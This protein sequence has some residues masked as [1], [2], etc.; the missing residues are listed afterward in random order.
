M[1]R[2]TDKLKLILMIIEVM[3]DKQKEEFT[4]RQNPGIIAQ[5]LQQLANIIGVVK[6]EFPET[7]PSDQIKDKSQDSKQ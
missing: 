5:N 7:G 6:N 2:I 3:S 4:K 1:E